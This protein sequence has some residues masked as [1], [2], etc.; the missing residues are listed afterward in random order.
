MRPATALVLAAIVVAAGTAAA[1]TKVVQQHH[2]D[3]FSMMGQTQPATDE[4]HVTWIGDGRLRLDQ[5]STSSIVALDENTLYLIDHDDRTYTEVE[6]PID[7]D[8]LLPPGMADQVKAMMQFEFTVT[9]TEETKKVGEWQATRYDLTMTSGMANMT[10][11]LWASTETPIDVAAYVDLYSRLISLQPGMEGMVEQ[12]RRVDGFVVEQETTTSMKVMGDQTVGS[13]N[14][15]TS[16]ESVD[17]PADTYRPPSDYD[18]EE[19]DFMAM[20]QR[21]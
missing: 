15:V 12:L 21:R 2:Q 20:M 13:S 17:A 7:I 9:P 5:G 6:L 8:S 4:E 16:I 1:D 14:L 18:R 10:S 19:F 3:G 11:V